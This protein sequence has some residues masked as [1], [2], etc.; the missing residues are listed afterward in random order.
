MVPMMMAGT[1][2]FIQ[3]FQLRVGT[4]YY[5]HKMVEYDLKLTFEGNA[6]RFHHDRVHS[7][8]QAPGE[9][10]FASLQDPFTVNTVGNYER[11][12]ISVLDMLAALFPF[13]FVVLCVAID[14]PVVWTRIW[15]CFFFLAVL[16]GLFSWITVVPDSGG[17]AVCQKRLSSSQYSVK[18][19]SQERTVW[20]LLN[21]SPLSR[22]CADMMFSGHTY[23]VT[24]FAFGLHE[25]TRVASRTLTAETRIMLESLVAVTAII[26][27]SIEVY[28]VLKSHFHYT[29]DVVMAVIMTYLLYT[30]SVIAVVSTK[31][32][33]P[34]FERKKELLELID[35]SWTEANE[36]WDMNENNK[37]MFNGLDSSG[38]ISLGCCCCAWS[39]QWIYSH[40]SLRNIHN[41]LVKATENRTDLLKFDANSKYLMQSEMAMLQE[42]SLEH[43]ERE[44]QPTE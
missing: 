12:D 37:W 13:L 19:Y 15:C 28:F 4:Y 42:C 5:V 41:D 36:D 24:I 25:C 34:G 16:K 17:W 26:H 10:S 21:M 39:R 1:G 9:V 30:N 40:N 2:F 35:K 43:W 23:F 3:N 18:W 32:A 14:E 44:Y 11:V 29:A 33:T 7:F 22:L 8:G 27:Q 38:S 6:S 31:W 20:E